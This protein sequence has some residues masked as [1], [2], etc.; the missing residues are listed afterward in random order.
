MIQPTC[1][2]NQKDNPVGDVSKVNAEITRSVSSHR[3]GKQPLD[4][5][6]YNVEMLKR[7]VA[8]KHSL[9]QFKQR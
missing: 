9:K 1:T 7:F 2:I 6:M 4:F 8:C 3:E 5:Y